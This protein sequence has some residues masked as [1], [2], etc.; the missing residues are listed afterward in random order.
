MTY[1]VTNIASEVPNT[2]LQKYTGDTGIVNRLVLVGVDTQIA[3]EA[4]AKELDTWKDNLNEA[5]S[6]RWIATPK[7]VEVTVEQEDTVKK[8]FDTGVTEPVRKGKKTVTYLLERLPIFNKNDIFKLD[9]G[10][11]GIYEITD[12]KYIKGWTDDGIKFLPYTIDSI[13][14]VPETDKTG[15]ENPHVAIRVVYSDVMEFN[16]YQ[17]AINPF[18]DGDATVT[19]VQ[20]DWD[21]AIEIK[22]IKSLQIEIDSLTAT[23][24]N[25][26]L[27]GY[28]SVAYSGAVKDDI[29]FRK[30]SLTA[31]AITLTS[32]TESAVKGTYAAVFATQTAGTFYCSLLPQGQATTYW[33]ETPGYDS[34]ILS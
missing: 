31:N 2:G 12:K 16:K 29:Y 20:E 32:L 18:T 1:N 9:D 10:A 25:I 14:V 28:D 21:P 11:Y 7:V 26:T 24:C 23:G 6:L 34:A 13:E 33:V 5:P 8:T 17:V 27:K 19:S 15:S 22:G 4:L 30:G 3:T